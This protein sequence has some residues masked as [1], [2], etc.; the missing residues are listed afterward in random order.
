MHWGPN[1]EAGGN[2]DEDRAWSNLKSER[3]NL[4]A[5]KEIKRVKK[6]EMMAFITD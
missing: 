1:G 6:S 3:D 5:S 2:S 4:R